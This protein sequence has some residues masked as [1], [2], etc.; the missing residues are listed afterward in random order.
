MRVLVGWK[1]HRGQGQAGGQRECPKGKTRCRMQGDKRKQS[2][3]KEEGKDV[4]ELLEQQKKE[5]AEQDSNEEDKE[6][7]LSTS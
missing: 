1:W 4:L 7:Q 6:L 3:G 2:V 5:E